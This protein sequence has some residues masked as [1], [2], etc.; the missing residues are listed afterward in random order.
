MDKANDRQVGGT[1]YR[2]HGRG[3]LQHWDLVTIFNLDYFQAQILRYVMRW[4]SKGG[5]EDLEKARHYLDK[6][7]EVAG[8]W[9]ALPSA[10]DAPE[11]A[12]TK[13]SEWNTG[14][15]YCA[16]LPHYGPCA[17]AGCECTTTVTAKDWKGPTVHYIPCPTCGH[18]RSSHQ[19]DRF[20]CAFMQ[21]NG[22]RCGCTTKF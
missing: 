8:E 5:R 17:L 16:H 18:A 4:K 13:R 9:L 14:C 10:P 12:G 15:P 11:P 1:H 3:D 21:E 19:V 20:G 7:L 22:E 6:Y 2:A